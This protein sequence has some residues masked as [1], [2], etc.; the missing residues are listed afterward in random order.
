MQRV[1]QAL[2]AAIAEARALRGRLERDLKRLDD[3][4]LRRSLLDELPEPG[5]EAPGLDELAALAAMFSEAAPGPW[6]PPGPRRRK[7]RR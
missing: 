6:R 3:P 5:P 1:D 2:E 7:R 4:R